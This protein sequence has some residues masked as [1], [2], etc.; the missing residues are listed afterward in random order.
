VNI[1]ADEPRWLP[2]AGWAAALVLVAAAV[3]ARLGVLQAYPEPVG[4]DGYWYAVQIRSLL[5]EGTTY[6][7]SLPGSLWFLLP[8][9][10]GGGVVEGIKLGAA[11]GASLQ[12]LAAFALGR[13]LARSTAAGVVAAAVVATS[14]ASIYLTT[15]FVKQGIALAAL[16]GFLAA[17]AAAWDQPT[18]GRIALAC[19]AGLA[20]GLSHKLAFAI[21]LGAAGAV[22]LAAWRRRGGSLRWPV[23]AVLVGAGFL[24]VTRARWAGMLSTS[25]ELSL[26]AIRFPSGAALHFGHEPAAA[27]VVALALVA[28]RRPLSPVA[29]ALIGTALLVAV[30][31]L[32]VSDPEGIGLRLR[33]AAHLAL[34]PLLGLLLVALVRSPARANLVA[35][36]VLV[37]LVLARPRAS[38]QGVVRVNRSLVEA[39]RGSAR[40]LPPDSELVV[41]SRQLAF[42]LTWESRRPARTRPRDGTLGP[43]TVRVVPAALLDREDRAAIAGLPGARDLHPLLVMPESTYRAFLARLSPAARSRWDRWDRSGELPR[44]RASEYSRMF[45]EG[46]P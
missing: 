13:R 19:V 6:Y 25:P 42:L 41:P 34:A 17:L 20:A 7:P 36:A 14:P 9:A 27:A 23:V 37:G 4:V 21:G 11:V 30:P 24:I 12:A 3:H 10:A 43:R 16:A 29:W 22:A 28:L 26:P 2:W 5:E 45:E 38:E 8:F 39:A 31:W 32:D 1:V 46:K 35:C 40:V 44:P 18:R 33:L 15:E